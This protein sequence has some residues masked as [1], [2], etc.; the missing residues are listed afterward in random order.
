[1]IAVSHA[2]ANWLGEIRDHGPVVLHNGVDVYG[3]PRALGEAPRAVFVG[4]FNGWKGQETF[5]EAASIAH[6]RVST[7]TFALV[8]GAVPSDQETAV[9]VQ[10]QAESIDPTGT[11]LQLLGELPD[12]REAMREAWLVAV[13]S[14]QPDPFPNVVLEAMAEGRAVVGSDLGGIPEMV[15]NGRTGELVRPGDADRLADAMSRIL[16]DRGVA[17]SMGRAGRTE[18]DLR[19]SRDRLRTDWRAMLRATAGL[20]AE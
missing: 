9:A 6:G 13:P 17:E 4:R 2:V 19:F 18:V 14:T 3:D 1:V 20:E 15:V 7:A 12:S 11:W 8:G 5:M 10:L 16:G